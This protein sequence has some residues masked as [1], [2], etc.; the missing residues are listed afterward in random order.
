MW[1]RERIYKG[2]AAKRELEPKRSDLRLSSIGDCERKLWAIRRGIAE[3]EFEGRVLSIFETGHAIEELVVTML[4]TA[5]FIV[6]DRQWEVQLPGLDAK[7][8]I[9]GQIEHKGAWALLEIKSANDNQWSQCNEVGYQ[10]WKPAYY[11][12]LQCYLGALQLDFAIAIVFNKNTSDIYPE[13]LHFDPIHYGRLVEKARRV[14]EAPELPDRP[15]E[16][17][18]Q[19]SE[20]CKWCSVNSECWG[21]LQ[22]GSVKFD[23]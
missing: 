4:T 6:T 16:A 23:A 20:F 21:P 5:G 2:L 13:K 12:T 3:S 7:G 14:I 18:S 10:A 1:I 9:D 22:L 11:D 19:Y 17:R 15:A 8:H